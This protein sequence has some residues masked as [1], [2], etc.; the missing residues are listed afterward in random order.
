MLSLIGFTTV[1]VFVALLYAVAVLW[2]WWFW[3]DFRLDG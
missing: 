1:A 3:G 2:N